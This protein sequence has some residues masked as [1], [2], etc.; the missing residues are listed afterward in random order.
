MKTET[1]FYVIE[2]PSA[3]RGNCLLGEGTSKAAAWLD[4]FG[5]NPSK[6]MKRGAWCREVTED[7]LNDLRHESAN[8]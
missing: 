2:K 1:V 8:R 7:E 4:A 5:P 3:I 6:Q